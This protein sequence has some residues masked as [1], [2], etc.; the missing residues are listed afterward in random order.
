M[1]PS[2]PYGTS[3]GPATTPREVDEHVKTNPVKIES[4]GQ[5]SH[6]IPTPKKVTLSKQ[7]ANSR[8]KVNAKQ[9]VP[10]ATTSPRTI[11]VEKN[12]ILP[13]TGEHNS[14]S[15]TRIG[16]ILLAVTTLF[17]GLMFKKRKEK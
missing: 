12:A 4:T 17:G 3:I 16:V 6:G 5:V 15:I 2:R 11:N 7:P 8:D 9:S 14:N 13:Q 1:Q 10:A